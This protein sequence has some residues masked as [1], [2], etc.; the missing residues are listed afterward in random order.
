M[1]DTTSIDPAVMRA[2]CERARTLRID[3]SASV[4]AYGAKAQREIGTF[5]SLALARMMETDLSPMERTL[6]LFIARVRDCD[7]S[8]VGKGLLSKLFGGGAVNALREA[9]EKSA[10]AIEKSADEMTDMRV[11]LLRDQALLERLG[12]K[13]DALYQELN[14]LCICGQERL[15]QLRAQPIPEGTD[16]AGATRAADQKAAIDRFERRLSD[17][18]ITR[19]ACAQLSAQ[20]S[21]VQQSDLRTADKLQATLSNTLPLWRAQMMTALGMARA[22]DGMD[23]QNAA[24]RAL[25]GGIRQNTRTLKQQQRTLGK[26]TGNADDLQDAAQKGEALLRELEE[27]ER[28]LKEQT[29]LREGTAS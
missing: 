26:K 22:M 4:M 1:P 6:E 17:L 9:Y 5:T 8:R 29:Q 16:L 11:A 3:D 19:T 10:P 28:S 12:E 13:N 15:R 23:L 14:A 24:A 20:L 21:I 2:A 25:A 7:A 18:E 27:I